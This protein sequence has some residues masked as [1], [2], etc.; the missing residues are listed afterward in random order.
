M[1]IEIERKFLVKGDHPTTDGLDIEQAYLTADSGI[2]VRVRIEPGRAVLA[3]KGQPQGPE[4]ISRPEFE[5]EIPVEEAREIMQLRVSDV[6]QKTRYH[7]HEG[8]HL[9]EID[10]FR[11]ANAGLVIA[12]IE[13]SDENESF[14]CPDWV[15]SEVTSDPRYSNSYLAKTPYTHWEEGFPAAAA[16][17]CSI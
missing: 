2:T 11:G 14:H 9:W 7:H 16:G 12:E 8:Q 4:G 1:A 6:V 3:I 17:P 13:L 5:Y 15:G 10:V